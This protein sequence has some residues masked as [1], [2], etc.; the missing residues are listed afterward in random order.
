MTI[1]K[2]NRTYM[3]YGTK[4]FD[5]EGVNLNEKDLEAKLESEGPFGFHCEIYDNNTKAKCT[6]YY[7]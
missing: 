2:I 1:T 7:D 3:G 5:V 6:C 4:T